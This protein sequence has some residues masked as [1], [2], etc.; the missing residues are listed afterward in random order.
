MDVLEKGGYHR[1]GI[2][3]R[4]PVLAPGHTTGSVTDKIGSE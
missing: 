4:P 1:P 3:E 2:I